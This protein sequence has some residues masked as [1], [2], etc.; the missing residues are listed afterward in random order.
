MWYTSVVYNNIKKLL[1]T[2]YHLVVWL[3][4]YEG[5]ENHLILRKKQVLHY[6]YYNRIIK[7]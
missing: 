1:K 3:Y 2:N 7:L 4:L 6:T 5:L